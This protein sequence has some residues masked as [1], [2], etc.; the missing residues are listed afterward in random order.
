MGGGY[1]NL[2]AKVHGGVQ[3]GGCRALQ[4][5]RDDLRG[6]GARAGLRRRGLSDWV[7]KA[8][9]ADCG[10]GDDPFQIA[11]DPRRST[12]RS[13]Q[14]AP[15]IFEHIE[16]VYNRVRIHSALGYMSPAEFEEANWPDDGGRPKAA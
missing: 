8:D 13:T 16:A 9:T 6:G 5:V 4:K 14:V 1:G 15:D 10:A 3:A 11:E 7:K 2:I 12:P